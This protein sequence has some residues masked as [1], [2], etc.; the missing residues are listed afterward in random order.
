MSGQYR[1]L[2]KDDDGMSSCIVKIWNLDEAQGAS[3]TQF[4]LLKFYWSVVKL[5][6]G[7]SLDLIL[8]IYII[9]IATIH[10]FFGVYICL[11]ISFYEY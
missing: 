4:L 10:K 11:R 8:M 2:L 1:L 3:E 7:V 9:D 5:S 6:F